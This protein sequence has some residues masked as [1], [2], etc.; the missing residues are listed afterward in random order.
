VAGTFNVGSGVRSSLG[1]LVEAMAVVLGR[2]ARVVCTGQFRVGDI[3]HALADTVRLTRALGENAFIGLRDGVAGFLDWVAGE[4]LEGGAN[5]RF[6]RS[7]AEMRERGL[8]LVGSTPPDAR[9]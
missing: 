9:R 6:D 5:D 3:R 2:E 4:A 8:L 1:D 7:L